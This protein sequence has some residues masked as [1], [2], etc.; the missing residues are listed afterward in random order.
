MYSYLGAL[1]AQRPLYPA[2]LLIKLRSCA[3][4]SLHPFLRTFFFFSL[5]FRR[6]RLVLD[7]IGCQK[8]VHVGRVRLVASKQ[9]T[10][11]WFCP[12][13]FASNILSYPR[14]L[15][16]AGPPS[17]FLE[18]LLSTLCFTNYRDFHLFFVSGDC[19]R[20]SR[21]SCEE[22]GGST[23]IRREKSARDDE[24]Q[25]AWHGDDSV[26]AQYYAS[27]RKPGD[28]YVTIVKRARAR[29]REKR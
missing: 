19:A 13:Q 18:L 23:A 11:G 29:A 8:V 27:T 20:I 17:T 6:L 9:I 2:F 10:R 22:N 7:V 26:S 5:F 28:F 15:Y 24:S 4:G 21:V 14:G 12:L 3:P 25:A 16:A 1:K